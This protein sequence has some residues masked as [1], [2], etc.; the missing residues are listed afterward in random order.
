M[1]HRK[2]R[3]GTKRRA[4]LDA[5]VSGDKT[6]AQLA[7]ISGLSGNDAAAALRLMERKGLCRWAQPRA[8]PGGGG[9]ESQLWTSRPPQKARAM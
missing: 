7:T 9:S 6:T 5:L 3:E 2:P 8:W 4:M 1:Q